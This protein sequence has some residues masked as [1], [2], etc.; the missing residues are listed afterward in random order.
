MLLI[1]DIIHTIYYI[2]AYNTIVIT[3]PTNYKLIS[4]NFHIS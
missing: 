1:D 2:H 4:V 3:A